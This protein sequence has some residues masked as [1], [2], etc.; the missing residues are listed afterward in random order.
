MRRPVPVHLVT[1][2]LGSGK[3]TALRDAFARL[4]PPDERWA[5]LVNEFGEVGL[6][7][8]RLRAEGLGEVREIAG[9]C[10]CCTSGPQLHLHLVRILREVR[11]DRL[12]IEPTGLA[13][14]G[15]IVDLLARPG[16]REV[17]DR[18][19]VIT[20]VDLSRWQDPA[21]R[22][23]DAW[24]AQSEAADIL[25]GNHADRVSGPEREA[26]LAEGRSLW[27]P[28]AVV[29]TT[30]WGRL[31][32]AWLAPRDPG[33][34][35]FVP[36][37]QPESWLARPGSEHGHDAEAVVSLGWVHDPGRVHDAGR[38]RAFLRAVLAGGAGAPAGC[39]RLKG[40]LRTA[41]GWV[42]VQGVPDRLE[43]VP[44][45][46]RR[47]NRLELLL[48]ADPAPTADRIAAAWDET[49]LA[50]ER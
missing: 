21:L 16:L 38:L 17:V 1:G 7:G 32:P 24:L 45:Q 48:P 35:R 44:T 33:P 11:P 46:H 26:F 30:T 47:D 6:D 12:W 14:P 40:L 3:T 18:R 28:K 10:V 36:L 39:L 5:V 41:R 22:R 49:V 42:D 23:Q 29:A 34:I 19:P 2:W 15:A 4:R 20:L 9:G 25:V 27:P 43:V 50:P 31:D 37:E 13:A 8:E